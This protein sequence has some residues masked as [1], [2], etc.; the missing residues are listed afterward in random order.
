[1]SNVLAKAD[2]VFCFAVNVIM[3]CFIIKGHIIKRKTTDT[4]RNGIETTLIFNVGQKLRTKD[5][6]RIR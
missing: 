2:N 4:H 3:L 6:D 5:D 1:M